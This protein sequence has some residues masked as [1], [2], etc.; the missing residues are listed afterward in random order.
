MTA[1]DQTDLNGTPSRLPKY[2]AVGL[3]A[4]FLFLGLWAMSLPQRFFDTL[5]AFDPYN[6]HFVQDVGAFQIGLG[7]VLVLASLVANTDALAIALFGVGIGSAAHT[8]SHLIGVD[9]GGNPGLDIPTL[10]VIS[11][12]LLG[13]GVSRW[14]HH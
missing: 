12:L 7:A 14:R 8:V 4:V 9:L 10:I 11:L 1:V 3:G 13:A 2:V 6:Q 5:A